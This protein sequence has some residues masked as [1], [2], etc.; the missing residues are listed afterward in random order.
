MSR[1]TALAWLREDDPAR[2]QELWQMADR[3][4]RE[5]VGDEVHL[6]GLIEISNHCVRRCGYCGLRSGNRQLERYRMAAGEELEACIA[7]PE[8]EEQVQKEI[9]V[10]RKAYVTGTPTFYLNNRKLKYWRDADFLQAV[11]KEEIR[12]AKK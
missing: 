10:A 11:V 6:R 8:T 4:R 12:K 7:S 3:C 1:D 5:H 2:L 9:A